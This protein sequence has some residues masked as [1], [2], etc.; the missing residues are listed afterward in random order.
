MQYSITFLNNYTLN[1]G[2]KIVLVRNQ[3]NRERQTHKRHK[4]KQCRCVLSNANEELELFPNA[5]S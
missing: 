2:K 3:R 4:I 5:Q 1:E